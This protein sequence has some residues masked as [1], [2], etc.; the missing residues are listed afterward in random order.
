[1]R[2]SQDGHYTAGQ[3][4]HCTKPR[5]T[6]TEACLPAINVAQHS[7]LQKKACI[8]RSRHMC[9]SHFKGRTAGSHYESRCL[10]ARQRAYIDVV[11]PMLLIQHAREL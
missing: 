5:Q 10:E 1:M 3:R 4:C 8:F 9:E 6:H 11:H 2:Q 7:D